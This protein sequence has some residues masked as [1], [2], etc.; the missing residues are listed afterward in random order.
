MNIAYIVDALIIYNLVVICCG[1]VAR[2]VE[3]EDDDYSLVKNGRPIVSCI[4][5]N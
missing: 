4:K 2:L 5:R 3:T 1:Q